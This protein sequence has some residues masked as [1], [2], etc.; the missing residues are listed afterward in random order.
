ML[1]ELNGDEVTKEHGVQQQYYQTP[2]C[3]T[4]LLA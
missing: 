4:A 2:V 1:S 3:F